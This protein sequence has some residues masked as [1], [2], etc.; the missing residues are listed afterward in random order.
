MN[1]A[2]PT[3]E[4]VMKAHQYLYYVGPHNVWSDY[5]YDQFCDRHGLDGKG[6]SDRASDY[7]AEVV[8]LAHEILK[9]PFKYANI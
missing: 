3:P 7:P 1:D 2:K 8:K 4:Q 5:E 9:E 6:G